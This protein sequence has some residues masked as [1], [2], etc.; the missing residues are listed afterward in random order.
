MMKLKSLI[1]GL[2]GAL[3]VFLSA[4]VVWTDPPFPSAEDQVTLYYDATEGNGELAG[5]IPVYIHT[6]LITSG[7]SSPTDWQYV[8]M[9]WASTAPEWVMDYE[10]TNLWSYDFGGQS[11]ADFYG[12]ADGIDAEQLAMV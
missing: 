7:S 6:G 12:M 4:Q 2:L 5:I 9:P 1:V 8:N 11:L 3:P 10:G